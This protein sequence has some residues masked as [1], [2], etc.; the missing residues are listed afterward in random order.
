M[1]TSATALILP[2]LITI[3][4]AGC[5]DIDNIGPDPEDGDLRLIIHLDDLNYDL[6]PASMVLK[7]E[8]RNIAD[9][10]VVVEESFSFGTSL[11]PTITGSNGSKVILSYPILDYSPEYSLFE[12]GEVKKLEIDIAHMAPSMETDDTMIDFNWG[13]QDDYEISVGYWGSR[14]PLE[15]RSNTLTIHLEE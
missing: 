11:F 9:H 6:A 4:I 10:A 8:L 15:V 12:S 7:I 14:N 2:L 3:L 1:R 13:I 5:F